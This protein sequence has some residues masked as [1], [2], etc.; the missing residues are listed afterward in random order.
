MKKRIMTVFLAVLATALFAAGQK[1]EPPQKVLY[2]ILS[3]A[4]EGNEK[5]VDEEFAPIS[6]DILPSVLYEEEASRRVGENGQTPALSLPTGSI[7]ISSFDDFREIMKYF[8]F[9][10]RGNA[11]RTDENGNR[12]FI[13]Y[14]DI[15]NRRFEPYFEAVCLPDGEE[16]AVFSE[17]DEETLFENVREYIKR[18]DKLTEMYP[19]F[20]LTLVY[21]DNGWE[22]DMETKESINAWNMAMSPYCPPDKAQVKRLIAKLFALSDK[23]TASS[24][25]YTEKKESGSVGAAESAGFEGCGCSG[26]TGQEE[27]NEPSGDSGEETVCEEENRGSGEEVVHEEA[28]ETVSVEVTE[29]LWY[30]YEETLEFPTTDRYPFYDIRAGL[31]LIHYQ[32]E[33]AFA[34]AVEENKVKL[35]AEAVRYLNTLSLEELHQIR[36]SD[37]GDAAYRDLTDCLNRALGEPLIDCAVFSWMNVIEQDDWNEEAAP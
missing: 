16:N 20:P 32:S 28:A 2:R 6:V 21:R 26:C 13:G 7:P 11:F 22:P 24:S 14:V 19:S 29:P 37:P 36:M 18:D 31:Y 4:K 10:I 33:E 25:E 27:K 35:H 12:L 1:E 34:R 5:A 3:I 17:I 30:E 8:D 15:T 9:K 23:K